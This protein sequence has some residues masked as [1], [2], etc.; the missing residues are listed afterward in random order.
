ML[1]CEVVGVGLLMWLDG[2]SP[3]LCSLMCCLGSRSR[4]LA[5]RAVVEAVRMLSGELLPSW[6]DGDACGVSGVGGAFFFFSSFE[7]WVCL[8][9]CL[10]LTASWPLALASSVAGVV[11]I[12]IGL[13]D[14]SW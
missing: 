11:V 7:P 12:C 6:Q 10:L 2:A 13:G 3:G 5:S 14:M 4:A 8:S 9:C 1:N